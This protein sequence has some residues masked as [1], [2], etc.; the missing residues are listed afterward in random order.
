MKYFESRAH[1][2]QLIAEQLVDKYRY[3][4]SAVVAL[5]DGGVL[6]GEEV[7]ARLHCPLMLIVS[8]DIEIPGEGL[9]FGGVSQTGAF[10]YNSELSAGEIY[11]YT[12]EFHGYLDEQK[13]TAFQHINRLLG[14]GG[15]VD[16]SL[17][18]D[19]VV[20]L[21][22]DGF[23]DEASID[24][25][26][27]LLKPIRTK[28]L[29]VASPVATVPAVDRMHVA[30]DELHIL[31]VKVNYMGVD[32]YYEDNQIPSHEETVKKINDIILRWR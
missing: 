1:A 21:V 28:K 6:V 26:L 8:K 24:V 11:H 2:G 10:T 13:R 12:T 25:A 5:N 29:V 20:I 9:S 30:A 32:H 17:L 27:D 23:G 14:D 31:D 3:E 22:S 4:N 16:T 19:R 7:A 15:T 18:K